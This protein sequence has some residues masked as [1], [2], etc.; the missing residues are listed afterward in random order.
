M[1]RLILIILIS[2]PLTGFA[3]M[4]D[5]DIAFS[6]KEL[7]DRPLGERIAFWAEK[8]LDTP[9]DTEPL[10]EYVRE[11]VIIAD[12]R[13]D[14][15][16]LTFRAAEL[17][18]GKDPADA[19]DVALD[20]RFIKRGM[21]ENG[22][23]L[24]YED[25]FRYGEDMLDSGKWGKEITSELGKTDLIQGLRGREKIVMVAGRDIPR[26][27]NLLQSGDIVFFVNFPGKMVRG[28]I[29]G[30]IG[31]IKKETD[32]VYLIHASGSKNK[33]G[34]VKKVLFA[35]YTG[36]MPFAGIRVSR[37]GTDNVLSK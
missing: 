30:H 12:E 31:I 34:K 16:Y 27:I 32:N 20:K 29:I 24:N 26:S 28:E 36:T 22:K 35:D 18:I 10:G 4:S 3:F 15:M 1:Y 17:G 21:I 37:F 11:N 23:I 2:Y 19:V 7:A 13:V 14:C 6:Q 9:Y 8:F 5:A 25:R 33:G